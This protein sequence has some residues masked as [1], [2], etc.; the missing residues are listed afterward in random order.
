MLEEDDSGQHFPAIERALSIIKARNVI[1]KGST[2]DKATRDLNLENKIKPEYELQI[3]SPSGDLPIEPTLV[4][5]DNRIDLRHLSSMARKLTRDK[6]LVVRGISERPRA[7][8]EV[9]RK[10]VQVLSKA[11]RWCEDW[12]LVQKTFVAMCQYRQLKKDAKAMYRKRLLCLYDSEFASI[13]FPR[14]LKISCVKRMG[15]HKLAMLFDKWRLKRYLFQI[16]LL[17]MSSNHQ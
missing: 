10:Q 8:S 3:H 15:K 7:Q 5:D 13:I 14:K 17:Y 4:C 9:I 12:Y 11:L 16:W 1:V 2:I 6:F